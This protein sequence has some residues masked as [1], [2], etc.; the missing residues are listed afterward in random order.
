MENDVAE[1]K[2]QEEAGDEEAGG[3]VTAERLASVD[4]WE[5]YRLISEDAEAPVCTVALRPGARAVAVEYAVWRQGEDSD[6][7]GTTGAVEWPADATQWGDEARE[8]VLRQVTYRYEED[9]GVLQEQLAFRFAG[10]PEGD[11]EEE[12]DED[13]DEDDD[14][15]SD[16]DE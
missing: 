7:P 3:R 1:R 11:F 5:M 6:E 8:D 12:T 2:K 4:A 16:D 9:L 15:E 10:P 14:E 13:D